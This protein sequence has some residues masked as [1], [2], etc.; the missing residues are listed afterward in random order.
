M[1]WMKKA[2]FKKY[3]YIFVHSIQINLQI[4]INVWLSNK[5]Y[6]AS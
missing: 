5:Q 4:E 3:I 1:H 2:I 6:L